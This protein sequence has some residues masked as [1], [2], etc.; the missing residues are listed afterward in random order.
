MTDEPRTVTITVTLPEDADDD[1]QPIQIV[2]EDGTVTFVD[3]LEALV[4][5]TEA[6]LEALTPNAADLEAWRFT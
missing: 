4:Q 5:I 6:D 3:D 2:W 1:L